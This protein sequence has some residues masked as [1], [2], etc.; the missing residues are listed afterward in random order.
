MAPLRRLQ[1]VTATAEAALPS[2]GLRRATRLGTGPPAGTSPK[3]DQ[4]WNGILIL[5]GDGVLP[6]GAMLPASTAGP[7]EWL[8]MLTRGSTPGRNEP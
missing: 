5:P 1:T 4:L 2:F 7:V 6:V 3:H 8:P